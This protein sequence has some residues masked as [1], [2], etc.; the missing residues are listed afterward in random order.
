MSTSVYNMLSRTKEKLQT[1]EPG[2]VAMYVCGMTTYDSMHV[3]HARCFLV[4]DVIRRYLEW[5]GQEVIHVQNVTDIDDKVITRAEELGV[6]PLGLAERYHLE[7]VDD[8]LTFGLLPPNVMSKAT[9][10]V[11]EII[12]IIT[13]L[14]AR[15]FA[16]CVESGVYFDVSRYEEDYPYGE[17]SGRDRGELLAGAR[18]EVDDRKDDPMDFALWK[19]AKPGE[20]S[21]KSPWGDG[22]PG[23]HIECSAMSLK[24]L[25][26]GFDI[27]GGG[28]DLIF[29]HHENEI[30]QSQ[31]HTEVRPAVRQWL[32]SGVVTVDGVKMSKSL[33]NII[34]LRD[35]L[36]K[37]GANEIKLAFLQTSYRTPV[38]Y[39]ETKIE[40]AR[41]ALGRLGA[42]L[43]AVDD[44]T[45]VSGGDATPKTSSLS[46]TL[47]QASGSTRKQF[48]E[49]MDDDFNTAR[50]IAAI[51][52]LVSKMNKF[53]RGLETS[54]SNVADMEAFRTSGDTVRELLGV[55]GINELGERV[56]VPELTEKL[57]EFLIT[58]RSD[59]RAQKL[60][61][62]ADRIRDDLQDLGIVLEDKS[63][64]TT[65][66]LE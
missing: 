13:D 17:L 38:D 10:H 24:Y 43:A 45:V 4:F 11:D 1:R 12:N 26:P 6:D 9:D 40:A 56:E 14:C 42:T 33:G 31:A 64:G 27:H 35:A 66:R 54:A 65:W 20:P 53:I 36:N 51:F 41:T 57:I 59:L 52:D 48:V 16:Y 8:C 60:F 32:H 37:H 55:L 44:S 46:D 34:N 47:V 18:L 22:R 5:R 49:A 15:G 58:L 50:A 23:W 63:G 25:G 62:V 7:S 28:T 2:K 21:W 30:A 19:T 29:P 3:G 61:E 39:S